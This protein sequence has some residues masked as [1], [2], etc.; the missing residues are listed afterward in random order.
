MTV[1]PARK[2]AAHRVSAARWRAIC[3]SLP[4]QPAAFAL[5]SAKTPLVRSICA[6]A[7]SFAS[8]VAVSE[9]LRRPEFEN[10]RAH[11]NYQK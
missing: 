10:A 8:S 11:R 5:G 3:F 4:F 6:T 7:C 1:A 9:A 2:A